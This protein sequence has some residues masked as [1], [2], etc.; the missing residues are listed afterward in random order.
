M[1]LLKL[2]SYSHKVQHYLDHY[3][4]DMNNGMVIQY[5]YTRIVEDRE[6][7]IN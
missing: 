3:Y 1:T 5:D 7:G 6:D 4:I 2:F